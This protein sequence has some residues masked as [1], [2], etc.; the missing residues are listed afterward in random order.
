MVSACYPTTSLLRELS[1]TRILTVR[2]PGK[3]RVVAVDYAVPVGIALDPGVGRVDQP[4][5]V[6]VSGERRKGDAGG[7]VG[8]E[9]SGTEAAVRRTT[10]G[11]GGR[12]ER[13]AGG[14]V[15][16]EGGTSGLPTPGSFTAARRGG[17]GRISGSV[18]FVAVGGG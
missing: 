15:G 18:D 3:A 2:V 13:G 17:G 9:G 16:R 12:S 4:V 6:L 1:R 10:V 5:A 8:G 7:S 14:S 11:G